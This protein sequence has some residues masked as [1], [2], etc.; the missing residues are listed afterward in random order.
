MIADM[1]TYVQLTGKPACAKYSPWGSVGF[2]F[3]VSKGCKFHA[4]HPLS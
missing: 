3:F 2:C 4:R 1:T